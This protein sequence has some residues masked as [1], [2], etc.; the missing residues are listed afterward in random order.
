MKRIRYNKW[1]SRRLWYMQKKLDDMSKQLNFMQLIDNLEREERH[2][3]AMSNLERLQSRF[4]RKY[5]KP[6][7]LAGST[8]GAFPWKPNENKKPY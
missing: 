1:L 2:K 6:P 7:P 4:P 5:R 3:R 8:G